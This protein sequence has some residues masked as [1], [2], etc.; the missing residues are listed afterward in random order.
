MHILFRRKDVRVAIVCFAAIIS[1]YSYTIYAIRQETFLDDFE[2]P[3]PMDDKD[4]AS[5]K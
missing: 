3:D 5:N 2:M 4:T 1:I